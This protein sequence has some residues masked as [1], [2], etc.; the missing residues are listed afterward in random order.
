MQAPVKEAINTIKKSFEDGGLKK[1]IN[2]V[3]TILINLGKTITNIAKVVIPP[4]AKAVDLIADNLNILLPIVATA[5]TAWK[6]WEII[7]SITALM[8]EHAASVTAESLAEAASLGTITLKQIAVGALTGEITLA[9]AAQY[10]WNLAMSLNPAVLILTG[11]TALTAGIV[12]FSAANG[13]ATQS[14]NDLVTAEESLKTANDNLSETYEG[15]GDK[16]SEFMDGVNSSSGVLD[17]FN[18]SIILSKDKQQELADK[19]D[20]VQTE[21]TEIART[22]KEKRTELT[23]EEIQRLDDLFAK[24]KN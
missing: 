3:K 2:T 22:A 18:D 13:D 16:I 11:I 5:V 17:G 12:A 14:T 15:I 6:A 10:A 24:Q 21:I 19:M 23:D 7:S 1:A 8:K 4:L 9:T 20:S